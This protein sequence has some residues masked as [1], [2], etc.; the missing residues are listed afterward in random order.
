MKIKLSFVVLSVGAL[1]GLSLLGGCSSLPGP[2]AGGPGNPASPLS[3]VRV[4][5]L[6]HD[7][8]S[9]RLAASI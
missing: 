1:T 2:A 7:P 5:G 3:E 8:L 6:V 4:G 9:P